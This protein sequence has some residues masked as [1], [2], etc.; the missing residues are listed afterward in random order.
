MEN[1]GLISYTW[2]PLLS[3]K[4]RSHV[5]LELSLRDQRGLQYVTQLVPTVSNCSHADDRSGY[6]GVSDP[7]GA[8]ACLH[9]DHTTGEDLNRAI[10]Q[11]MALVGHMPNKDRGDVTD[12]N[13]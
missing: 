4:T 7:S 2:S 5:I 9:K 13:S 11:A 8:Y 3:S 10:Q 12:S 1:P 6:M